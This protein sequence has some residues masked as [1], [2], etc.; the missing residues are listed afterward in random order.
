M[1]TVPGKLKGLS[2]RYRGRASEVEEDKDT[3]KREHHPQE[4]RRKRRGLATSLAWGTYLCSP[5]LPPLVFSL[6]LLSR[7]RNEETRGCK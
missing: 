3:K 4:P 5:S 2:Y 6:T 7:G 1:F